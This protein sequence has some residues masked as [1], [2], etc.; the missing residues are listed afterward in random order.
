MEAIL[1]FDLSV[2]RFVEDYIWNPVLDVIMPI[3]TYLGEGGVV[4]IITALILLLTKKYRKCGVA[5]ALGLIGSLV[6]VDWIIKPIVERPRPFNLEAWEG[7]FNYPD[8]V[9]KPS[10]WSFPSGHSSS[11]LAASVAL[12]C[13]NK[14]FG[15]PAVILGV[16]IAF[17]R[18][19]VHV[20][21]PT[22]VIVG[23]LVGAI[24]GVVAGFIA[25]RYY[26]SLENKIRDKRAAKA[27]AKADK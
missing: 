11:S 18:I 6:V 13:T 27:Q 9:S 16:L 10:S 2:F 1:N 14:K 24:L 23:I 17:S 20:H 26:P 4:W 19:Y 22:D 21:Y 12:L 7:I 3:I 25:N 8:L 15:I 5:M